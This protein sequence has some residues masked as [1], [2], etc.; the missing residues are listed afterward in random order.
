[1]METKI[2][3]AGAFLIPYAIMLTFVGIPAFF[4]ELIMGQYSGCG[5]VTVWSVAPLLQGK[6]ENVRTLSYRD[7]FTSVRIYLSI[8]RLNLHWTIII[9]PHKHN[10]V[11]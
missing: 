11:T 8:L 2:S 9:S 1:M 7:M 4:M 5:P 3:F 10:K 6:G